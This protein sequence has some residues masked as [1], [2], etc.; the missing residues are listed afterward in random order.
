MSS[1]RFSGRVASGG[2]RRAVLLCMVVP[3]GRLDRRAPPLPRPGRRPPEEAMSEAHLPAQH[4]QAIQEARLPP[5]DG[6]PGRPG[7]PEEPPA[8]GPPQAV[9]LTPA[10]PTPGVRSPRPNQIWRVERRATFQALRKGR[11]GRAG[12]LTVTWL[13]GDP[14]EPPRV[15][16][17]LGRRVGSAV[18]RNQ[19]RRRLR[20]CLRDAAPRLPPGA[21]L[22]GA[23]PDAASLS[24]EDLRMTLDRALDTVKVSDG[25]AR[26]LAT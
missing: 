4:P 23:S 2:R 1:E 3:A 21:Y 6:D 22:I 9:G 12:A 15:A 11:R 18:V 26:R 24:Y 25:R 17:A 7:D 20:G 10:L 14:A 5:S 19:L 8:Q 16:F 13:E